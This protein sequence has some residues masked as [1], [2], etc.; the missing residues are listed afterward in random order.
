MWIMIAGPYGHNT[1]SKEARE[2]NLRYLNQIAVEVFKLG[3]TPII[4]VN[5][6]LPMIQLA[7]ADYAS[8]IM[9]LSIEHL[10]TL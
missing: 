9:P 7:E 2:E 8:T 4:G 3:H 10:P 6:A 5:L 1:E